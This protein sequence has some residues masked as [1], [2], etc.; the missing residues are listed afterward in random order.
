M[1]KQHSLLP[2]SAQFMNFLGLLVEGV[3]SVVALKSLDGV[4]VFANAAM[5][6]ALGVPPGCIVGSVD[7]SWMP[8]PACA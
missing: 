7:A 8:A 2:G 6:T 5:E 1:N 4:Y 3:A